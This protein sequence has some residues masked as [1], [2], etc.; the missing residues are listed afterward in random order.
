MPETPASPP[1]PPR[2]PR[3]RYFDGT[4]ERYGDAL[5]IQRN[6]YI[7]LDKYGG[8]DAILE[9]VGKGDLE[10]LEKL[11]LAARLALEMP[12]VDPETGRGADEEDVRLALD[13][14]WENLAPESHEHRPQNP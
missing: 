10:A 5:R 11:L 3:L 2:R 13:K 4:R 14:L 8:P 7:A 6:L 12:P 1:P 9:A